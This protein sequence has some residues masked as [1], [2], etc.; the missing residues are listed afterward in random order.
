[1][2]DILILL[3]ECQLVICGANRATAQ[4]VLKVL[5]VCSEWCVSEWWSAEGHEVENV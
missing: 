5:L 3:R 1:M 2:L 4:T